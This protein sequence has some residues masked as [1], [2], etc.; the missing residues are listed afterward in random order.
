MKI[1][2]KEKMHF[3]LIYLGSVYTKIRILPQKLW[4]VARV[5]SHGQIDTKVNTEG[6]LSGFQDFFLQP[7]IKDRPNIDVVSDQ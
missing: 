5:Q 7:I 3:F 6:P 4:S 2:K 1:Y